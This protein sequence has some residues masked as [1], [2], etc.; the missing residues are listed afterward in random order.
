MGK[1]H[2]LLN[3]YHLDSPN[4]GESKTELPINIM[5]FTRSIWLFNTL[6]VFTTWCLFQYANRLH[7]NISPYAIELLTICGAHASLQ[8]TSNLVNKYFSL[9]NGTYAL[10]LFNCRRSELQPLKPFK[11]IIFCDFIRTNY[12]SA[13]SLLQY[14]GTLVPEILIGKPFINLCRWKILPSEQD[15]ICWL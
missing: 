7:Q 12:F 2:F 8:H 13:R 10:G 14:I 5:Q 6:T 11:S 15:V 3:W 9:T 4:S 1:Y